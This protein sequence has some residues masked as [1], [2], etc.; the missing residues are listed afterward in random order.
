MSVVQPHTDVEYPESDG[1]PMGETDLHRDWMFRIL[2]LLKYR[3]RGQQIYVSSD[4]LV[5]FEEGNPRKFVV[6]DVFVVKDCAPARRRVFKTWE[7]GRSPD[8][9]WEVTSRYTR[10]EDEVFKP[11]SYAQIGVKEYFLYDPPGDYLRPALIG[12]R[13]ADDQFARIQPNPA[14]ALLCQELG[15][16]LGLDGSELVISDSHTGELLRT[17]AEAAEEELRQLRARLEDRESV[18]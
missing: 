3:C 1:K 15:I 14:G 16:L 5:Y 12:F 8:V 13:F 18:E 17:R 11:Q 7:E 2:E 6:P 9:V 4:L 10:R